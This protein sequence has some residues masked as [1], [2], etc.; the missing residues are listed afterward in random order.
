MSKRLPTIDRRSRVRQVDSFA[1]RH[2]I[3]I[4]ICMFYIR[5]SPPS[6]SKISPVR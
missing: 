5:F 3:Q 4:A 6:E 2:D 1:R